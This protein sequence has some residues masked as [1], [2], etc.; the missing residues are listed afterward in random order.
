MNV[1]NIS[2][3]LLAM[4]GLFSDE[5]KKKLLEK[6]FSTLEIDET[7]KDL[8]HLGY[9]DD[10]RE[11]NLF[12]E[13]SLRKGMGPF[14]IEVKLR[15]RTA[16]GVVDI[17]EEKQRELIC[18]HIEKKGSTPKDKLYRFLER[19]GFDNALIREILLN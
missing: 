1:V 13:R 10:E 15:Q 5:L 18:Q 8:E 11:L 3:K 9:L 6:G 7:V 14:L 17:S 19:K 4:K 16:Y 2:Y 12:I